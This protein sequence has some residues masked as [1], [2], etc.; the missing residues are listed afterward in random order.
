MYHVPRTHGRSAGG[1]GSGSDGF[2]GDWAGGL[3]LAVFVVWWRS[4]ASPRTAHAYARASRAPRSGRVGPARFTCG[5]AWVSRLSP[6]LREQPTV[7]AIC[8]RHHRHAHEP[9]RALENNSNTVIDSPQPGA[10]Q[11]ARAT[12][13]RISAA[14]PS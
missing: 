1:R 5:R 14:M 9:P 4:A 3:L 8:T 11:R 13:P 7:N 12:E 6:L 2:G 10:S